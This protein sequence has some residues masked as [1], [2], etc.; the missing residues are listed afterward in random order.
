MKQEKMN[1]LVAALEGAGFELTAFQE[2]C[3]KFISPE[4]K[5]P[6]IAPGD[7]ERIGLQYRL[8]LVEL[9]GGT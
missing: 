3:V 6:D 1:R 8:E 4:G 2:Q 5:P 9:K 7:V